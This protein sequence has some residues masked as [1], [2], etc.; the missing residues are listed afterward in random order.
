MNLPRASA[1][2]FFSY[3]P[4]E[5]GILLFRAK[6]GI[7]SVLYYSLIILF[8]FTNVGFII[9]SDYDYHPRPSG[10]GVQLINP[11]H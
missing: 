8:L 7:P 4:K 5:Q 6:A 1:R 3:F 10:R 2:G 9:S 11:I